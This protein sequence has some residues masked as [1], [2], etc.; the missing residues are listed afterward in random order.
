MEA[1]PALARA[2]EGWHAP[3]AAGEIAGAPTMHVARQPILDVKRAVSAYELLFRGS[4][5]PVT[6]GVRATTNVVTAV[7]SDPAFADALGPHRGFINV[8]T[9]FLMSDSVEFLPPERTVIEILEDTRFTP[10][11]VARCLDLKARGYVLA[12]DDYIGCYADLAPVIDLIDIVKVDLMQVKREDLAKIAR[13][14]PGKALLAE[15]VETEDDFKAALDAGY[16]LFQGYFF[17]R[18]VTVGKIKADPNRLAA[19][20]VLGLM[21]RNAENEELEQEI[22]RHGLL[23]VGVLRLVNAAASGMSRPVTSVRQ[24]LMLVGRTQL[25]L[26][27]QM[28]IYLGASGADPATNPLLQLAA[29]RAKLMELL[30]IHVGRSGHRAFITGLVSMFDIAL[31][32][33]REEFCKRL[34]LDGEI[35]DALLRYAGQLGALL[36]LA[37]AIERD[38]PEELRRAYAAIPEI[39]GADLMHISVLAQR[40]AGSLGQEK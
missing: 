15:K 5:G 17:A 13:Q 1:S 3:P 18:P 37:E 29:A 4:A 38:D 39:S 33:T 9:K 7:F 26:W 8:D 14:L 10:E 27:L 21:A 23:V 34:G 40:W 22:K 16:T 30:A 31:G 2:T 25:Q 6:D 12:A 35:T 32:M 20:N 11:V 28:Q 19:V 24:A 36:A